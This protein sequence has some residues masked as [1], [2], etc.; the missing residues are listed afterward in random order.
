MTKWGMEPT[1][2]HIYEIAN[3]ARRAQHTMMTIAGLGIEP[4]RFLDVGT[5]P[6][7]LPWG[8]KREWKDCVVDCV[9]PFPEYLVFYGHK[10]FG[11]IGVFRTLD[12]VTETYDTITCIH[13]LEHIIDPVKFLRKIGEHLEPGGMLLV[14]T[15]NFSPKDH[16]NPFQR[17]HVFA[18]TVEGLAR[19]IEAAG[20]VPKTHMTH[21]WLYGQGTDVSVL[22][23][24]GHGN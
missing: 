17:A 22:M 5:G 23:V 13:T 21:G 7:L 8:L 14:E 11:E 16:N 18:Y 20:L 2:A 4:K 12:E 3:A 10:V 6:G 1:Q 9:E 24:A 15:P 19:T